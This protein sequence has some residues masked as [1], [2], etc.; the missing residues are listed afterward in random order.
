MR[1]IISRPARNLYYCPHRSKG[2][3]DAVGAKYY[4]YGGGS[5]AAGIGTEYNDLWSLNLANARWDVVPIGGSPLA[6]PRLGC[7]SGAAVV[8]GDQLYL[9]G[10]NFCAC[11]LYNW[12]RLTSLPFHTWI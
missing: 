7:I 3:L 5:G 6:P 4:V 1:R 11:V 9:Y 10:A 12:R 2:A 8:S